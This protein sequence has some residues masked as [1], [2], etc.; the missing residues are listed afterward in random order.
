MTDIHINEQADPGDGSVP[1][2]FSITE[3]TR[4]FGITT[5]TLRFY[6]AEGLLNPLRKGRHR[7]FNQRERTR[8]KLIL[9]GK[10][11]GFSLAEIREIVDMYDAEPGEP[12]QL[13]L[14]VDQI[15]MRRAELTQKMQDIELTLSELEQVET[16]CLE[17][18]TQLRAA[19]P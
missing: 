18:L 10:R 1:R 17:R 4:E 8:L 2:Y 3:L 15:A 9:R 19:K 13:T 12:G 16:K 14:L 11:L 7:L 6:E 5:R